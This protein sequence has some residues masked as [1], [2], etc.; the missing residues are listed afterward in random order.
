MNARA[1]Y[2]VPAPAKLNL[3]LHVV[4]R[5][6]DGYHR[7]ES[8]FM[9]IDWC[10][11][12]HFE[13]RTDGRIQRHD[14]GPKLPEND[15]CIQA[16][17]LIQTVSSSPLGV[18]IHLDKRIPSQAGMG[19]GSSDAASTLLALNRLWGLGLRSEQL[20]TLGLQL[21]ADVPF[22]LFGKNA[23]VTGIGEQLEAI[24]LPR[25]QFLVVKPEQGL[26]TAR[27]FSDPGLR[28]DSPPAIIFDFVE[29]PF[30]YGRND[31]QDVALK[32]CPELGT[33]LNWLAKAGLQGRMTGSGSAL[34]A[35]VPEG[36]QKD[37]PKCPFAHR[38]CENM[39][40]HPLK[41]WAG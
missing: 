24:E 17:R 6:A 1:I 13:L 27:I 5:R 38:F 7:L 3:F 20:L 36:W 4:G 40:S 34:F 35:P 41:G 21:G 12:L 8:A 2:D 31:L 23:W 19:G 14:L 22:F 29:N 28:R 11:T 39:P 26:P 32:H 10:D 15:L 33:A 16:A 30:N 25:G 18:D 37:I 9:L